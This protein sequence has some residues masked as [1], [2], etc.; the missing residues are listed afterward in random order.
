NYPKFCG[1]GKEID[2][3]LES[4][5]AKRVH[6]RTDCD[7]EFDEPFSK[8][9]NEALGALMNGLGQP[10]AVPATSAEAPGETDKDAGGP[11]YSRSHPF[12]AALL[13]NRKLNGE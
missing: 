2:A 5:G 7:V 8:W 12:P 6:P 11:R 4:L 9:V 13:T 1:F 10:A 3:R